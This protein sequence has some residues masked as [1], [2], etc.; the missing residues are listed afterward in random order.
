MSCSIMNYDCAYVLL[1]SVWSV[2]VGVV[3][4]VV[5]FELKRPWLLN[6]RV[7]GEGVNVDLFY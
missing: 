1:L 3:Y 4:D 6:G 2:G 5:V 7:E